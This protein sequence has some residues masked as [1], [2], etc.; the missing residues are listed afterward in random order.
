MLIKAFYLSWDISQ[1][2]SC[3]YFFFN[4]LSPF[5]WWLPPKQ[6]QSFFLYNSHWQFLTSFLCRNFVGSETIL[7]LDAFKTC[8]IWIYCSSAIFLKVHKSLAVFC[9]VLPFFKF[10]L[11]CLQTNFEKCT[12][13]HVTNVTDIIGKACDN[14]PGAVNKGLFIS[15]LRAF[16]GIFLI[17]YF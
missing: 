7:E 12:K 17:W 9:T 3:S 6:V 15:P 8:F 13:L 4:L 14:T 1:Q 5:L 2:L 11:S 16:P 10:S